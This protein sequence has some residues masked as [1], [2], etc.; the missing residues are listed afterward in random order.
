MIII[1]PYRFTSAASTLLT[2]LTASY[3]L[4]GNA[5]KN[6]G[7]NDGT[8]TNVTWGTGDISGQCGVFN[9][10]GY[11]NIIDSSDFTFGSSD[12]AYSIRIKRG[13]SSTHEIFVGQAAPSGANTG[14]SWSLRFQADNSIGFAM[15][16]NGIGVNYVDTGVQITDTN[17][18]NILVQRKG[19]VLELYVDAVLSYSNSSFFTGKTINNPTTQWGIGR[20]GE[21]TVLFFTGSIQ[22]NHLWNGRYLTSSEITELQTKRYPF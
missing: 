16:D 6:V 8:A 1:N 13:V 19:N 2:G 22:D 14:V 15:I 21:L 18:H 3:S 9:G 7:S 10:T 17:W 20:V 4:N 12:F 5:L 11:I